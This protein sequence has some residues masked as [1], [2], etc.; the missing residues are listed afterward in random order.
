VLVWKRR[1]ID[2][3]FAERKATLKIRS[4]KAEPATLFGIAPGS[5]HFKRLMRYRTLL[6]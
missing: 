6:M 5:L 4:L 2:T 3:S 1:K